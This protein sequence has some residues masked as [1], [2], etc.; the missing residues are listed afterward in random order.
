MDCQMPEM[1]GYAAAAAIRR[2]DGPAK[3]VPIVAFTANVMEGDRERCLAAGMEG[4]LA[5]PVTAHELRRAVERWAGARPRL[6]VAPARGSSSSRDVPR[7][8]SKFA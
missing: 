7:E 2:L 5:K 6:P 3:S 4:Y 8:L 1:D